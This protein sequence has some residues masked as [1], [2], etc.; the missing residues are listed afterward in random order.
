MSLGDVWA[1]MGRASGLDISSTLF[2]V[3]AAVALGILAG[4]LTLFLRWR[5]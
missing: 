1:G 3:L 5:P 2:W 4:V